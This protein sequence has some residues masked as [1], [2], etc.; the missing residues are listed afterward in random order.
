MTLEI[1]AA[2]ATLGVKIRGV[3]LSQPPDD[4]TFTQ[5]ENAYDSYGA[6]LFRHQRIN[7]QQSFGRK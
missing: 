6:T 1:T 7:A 3:D 5:I 2:G 4:E